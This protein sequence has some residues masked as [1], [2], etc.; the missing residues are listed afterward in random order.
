MLFPKVFV[1]PLLA[2][3]R[4]EDLNCFKFE[5]AQV[6]KLNDKNLCLQLLVLISDY[7]E[8]SYPFPYDLLI[9]FSKD[10]NAFTNIGVEQPQNMLEILQ[11]H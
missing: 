5:F 11:K 7:F 10:K 8:V 9:F 3:Q 4:L 6:A 1:S 2:D